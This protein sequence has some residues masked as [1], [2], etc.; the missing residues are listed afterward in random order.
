MV[1]PPTRRAGAGP[2]RRRRLEPDSNDSDTETPALAAQDRP[3]TMENEMKL[4]AMKS[5]MV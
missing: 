4:N 2:S 1:P 5:T 3:G